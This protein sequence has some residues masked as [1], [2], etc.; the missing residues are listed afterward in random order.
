MPEIPDAMKERGRPVDDHFIAAEQLFRRVPPD[1][2]NDGAEDFDI[3]SIELPDMSVLRGKYGHPEWARFNR[4]KYTDW[5]VIGFAVRHIAPPLTH[6]GVF[7]WTFSPH[8]APERNNYPHSEIRAF[9]NGV[10]I[11]M[12]RSD[13]IDPHLHLRWRDYLLRHIDKV[14][15]PQQ[16]VEFREDF[17]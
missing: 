7:V 4:G 11:D 17:P 10:H 14:I 3:E 6:L 2:W 13:R 12:K 16:Q 15:L 9:E 8:H 1:L 5:G